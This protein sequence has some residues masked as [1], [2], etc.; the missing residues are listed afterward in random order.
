M[1]ILNWQDLWKPCRAVMGIGSTFGN[2][3][4][5]FIQTL[6]HRGD[7]ISGSAEEIWQLK[8]SLEQECMTAEDK[9]RATQK[10]ID[11]LGEMGVTSDQAEQAFSLLYQQGLITD[12]ML[13]I[14]SE[15]IKTLDNNT[16]Q[17]GRLY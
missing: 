10:L 15:S 13:D 14:L 2:T 12:D 5:N 16:N 6:Q 11:K 1:Q 3:M 17:Y 4:N 9:A 7:I 8:E